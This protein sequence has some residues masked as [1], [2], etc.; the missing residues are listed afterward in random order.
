MYGEEKRG[1]VKLKVTHCK[2][3]KIESGIPLRKIRTCVMLQSFTVCSY[4]DFV[5]ALPLSNFSQLHDTSQ[6]DI[7]VCSFSSMCARTL[8]D[9]SSSSC[10][11]SQSLSAL[12]RVNLRL[13]NNERYVLKISRYGSIKQSLRHR[14][15]IPFLGLN[16]PWA[17]C[18]FSGDHREVM[19]PL[20]T[21]FLLL[22]DKIIITHFRGVFQILNE[23]VY[24]K[25]FDQ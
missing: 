21:H 15:W 12:P 5:A 14:L 18:L 22:Y 16:P 9:S 25:P 2:L 1:D 20:G 19:Y 24:V 23:L 10:L 7:P 13:M 17:T 8:Q 3:G 11:I 6:G 4:G